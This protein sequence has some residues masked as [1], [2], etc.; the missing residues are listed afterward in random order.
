MPPSP[1]QN[2]NVT[3]TD[4]EETTRLFGLDLL[5]AAAILLVLRAHTPVIRLLQ[6]V[7]TEIIPFAP[8]KNPIIRCLLIWVIAFATAALIYRLWE[9]PMTQLRDRKPAATG[10]PPR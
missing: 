5:R 1:T 9:K 4:R 7:C 8:Y 10:T 3:R 6:Y 2:L